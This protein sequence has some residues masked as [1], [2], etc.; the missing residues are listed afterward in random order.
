MAENSVKLV[1]LKR[2]DKKAKGIGQPVET[3]NEY[4]EYYPWGF[5]LELD[6]V[7]KRRQ[8]WVNGKD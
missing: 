2:S 6:Q 3:K 7:F 8:I 1:N 4:R 5:R